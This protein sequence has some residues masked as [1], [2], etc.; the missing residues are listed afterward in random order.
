M[1]LLGLGLLCLTGQLQLRLICQPAQAFGAYQCASGA[2]LIGYVLKEGCCAYFASI[3]SL[4]I[5]LS[6]AVAGPLGV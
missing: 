1:Y 3:A 6:V 4:W 5:Q 2:F